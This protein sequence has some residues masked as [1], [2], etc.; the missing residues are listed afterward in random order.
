MKAVKKQIPT[1]D[2][3]LT[4]ASKLLAQGGTAAVTTRAV[5]DAAG[6]TAPTLYHHFGDKDGL[7]RA[8]VAKGVATF[9]EHKRANHRTSDALADL[10]R[11]WGIWT[12]FALDQ[13][14]LFRLMI[15]STIDEPAV[16]QEAFD[17]MR[18]MIERLAVEGRLTTDTETAAR[19]M[20]AA[21]NG[22][23]SLF[24][25]GTPVVEITSTGQLLFEALIAKLVRTR[26]KTSM[27]RKH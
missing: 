2:Q 25:H 18:E 22:V 16:S 12:A 3:M 27:R 4:A 15:E 6:V 21:S 24:M 13:P 9:M 14:E 23:L 19:T 10:E 5:C 11:G 1:E 26:K 17:L 20:W 7:L 8:L